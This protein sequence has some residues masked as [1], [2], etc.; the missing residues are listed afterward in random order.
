MRSLNPLSGE[1][2]FRTYPTGNILYG[3]T[4]QSPKR[5]RYV[6]DSRQENRSEIKILDPMKR[7]PVVTHCAIMPAGLLVCKNLMLF[8]MF[9]RCAN[10]RPSARH[11][12][13]DQRESGA[14]IGS[15]R[16]RRMLRSYHLYVVKDVWIIGPDFQETL[17]ACFAAHAAR[18]FCRLRRAIVFFLI[19]S[20]RVTITSRRP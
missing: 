16:N 15:E 3:V 20:L 11:C 12:D 6:S 4:S 10:L 1:G 9:A 17:P 2:M 13:A 18:R 7:Q 8:R 14:V 19:C 5:G